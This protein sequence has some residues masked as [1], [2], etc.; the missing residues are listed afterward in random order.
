MST[1]KSDRRESKF[2]VL[3]N[4]IQLKKQVRELSIIRN[5]GYKVR[6]SAIPG[7]W[8]EWSEQSKQRWLDKESERLE[9]LKSLDRDFL[10][11]KREDVDKNL[12][13][14]VYEITSANSIVRPSCMAEADE[15]RVHQCRAVSACE[16]LRMDLQ[17]IIDTVPI[18]KNW[19]TQIQ[20]MID[21]EIA[22]IQAWKKS[23]NG[24]R[25][26]LRQ[27]ENEGIIAA[28]KDAISTAEDNKVLRAII[29]ALG[30]QF[31]EE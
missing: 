20:P 14:M 16:R 9:K 12:M 19:M 4:C 25:K 8:D 23:D 15:R 24:M 2:E 30:I 6:E 31:A 13:D 18:E 26:V 1:H 21:K 5:F 22:L 3:D 17:D 29:M 27:K 10:K 28:L 11:G 7:N